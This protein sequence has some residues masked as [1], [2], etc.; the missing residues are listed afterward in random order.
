MLLFLLS[1]PFLIWLL[2]VSCPPTAFCKVNLFSFS[3]WNYLLAPKFVTELHSMCTS[4]RYRQR[5]HSFGTRA[6]SP[7]TH[8]YPFTVFK[9]HGEPETRS[10]FPPPCKTGTF[11]RAFF[12]LLGFE[13]PLLYGG[14]AALLFLVLWNLTSHE[15]FAMSWFPVRPSV[16]G[17]SLKTHGDVGSKNTTASYH[18]TEWISHP[19]SEENTVV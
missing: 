9:T 1:L 7:A 4:I 2:C 12:S 10:C 13:S 15:A 8:W 11:L 16:E 14:N 5:N 19:G 18:I 17:R 6:S 3:V